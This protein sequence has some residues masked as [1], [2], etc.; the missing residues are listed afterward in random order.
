MYDWQQTRFFP[1]PMDLTGLL[2]I[3]LRGRERDGIVHAGS[4]YQS[5]CAQLEEFLSSLRD[6]VTGRP[7]VSSIVRAYEVTPASAP[8]RDGQ[9]DLIVRWQAVR[10]SDVPALISSLL[11]AFRCPVPRWLPSGRTGNHLPDG[12]FIAAGPGIAASTTSNLHDVLDLVPTARALLGLEPDV[13][14][15]GHPIGVA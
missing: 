11:P 13:S 1:L 12:W 14:L 4:D 3:N 5:L 7:I 15:H 9:P 6:E 2:R 8:Y 10:T